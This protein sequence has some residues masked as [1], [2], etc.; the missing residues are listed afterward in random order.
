MTTI[1]SSV[2]P[3]PGSRP[4]T[5]AQTVAAVADTAR[6]EAAVATVVRLL[7][8][9]A[10]VD[11]SLPARH[12]RRAARLARLVRSEPAK[13][14]TF[15]LTDQVLRTGGA[16]RA[17][18][19]R[20]ARRFAAVVRASGT[21]G[22]GPVDRLLLGAGR[23]AARL[24]PG[25]VM[26]LVTRRL[27]TEATEV[28]LPAEDPAFA[29]HVA[30]RRA[31]GVRPNVNVIGEA[32]LS[33]VEAR[34]RLDEILAR[35]ARPDVDY[36]SVKISAI[37]PNVSALAFDA[38]VAAVSER[39][40]DLYRAAQRRQPAAFV[41]LDMEEYRD[42]A[43]TVAAFRTVLGEPEFA[44]LDAGIVLQ[45]YLPDSHGEAEQLAG[46]AAER[47]R[48]GGGRVKI[49]LVKG[50]NLAMERVDAEIHGWPLATYA[51]KAEVDASYKK[52]LDTLAD[53]RYDDAVT[54]GVASH[55]L[56]DVA[57]ALELRR[58][59]VAAGRPDRI[60]IEMLEGMAPA[61]AEAVRAVAGGLVAYTPIV[62]RTDFPAA[63]AYLVRRL[64]E[65]TSPENFL[66]HLFDI[67]PCNERFTREAERFAA[68]VHARAALPTA[69]H[70]SQ[71]R[72]LEAPLDDVRTPF[73]N[74][75]DTD[76]S[77]EANRRWLSAVRAAGSA[78][79][80]PMLG[81]VAEVDA[82]VAQATA[83][84]PAWA[85]RPVGERAALVNA[86]GDALAARRGELLQVMAVEA[87]KTVAEGDP[88]VS[89]AVDFARYYA[90]E[91]LRLDALAGTGGATAGPLGPVVVAPPWNF[92]VAIA[93]GGVLAALAAGNTVVLK[94]APQAVRCARL[95]A[96]CCWEAGVPRDVLQLV[97]VPDDDA[98]RRLISHPDVAAVV[99]TGAWDTAQLFLGWRPEL[100]LHAETSG[101][102][103]LVILASADLDLALRDLVRSAFGH[104]GQKCSAAS[105]AILEAPLYDDPAVLAR[106]RHAVTTLRTGPAT[107]LATD[108]GPLIGPPGDNLQRALTQLDPGERWLVEPRQIGPAQWTPGVRLGVRPG[109]WFHTT[110]CFGPVLGVLRAND[111]D[112]AL[113]LQNAVPFGLTAGL[114]TLDEAEIASWVERVEAGNL[115]INRGITGAIVRRQPFGGW[116]RSAVGPTAKAG[117]PNYVATLQRW[118][119]GGRP[120]AEVAAAFAAWMD[121][122]GRRAHDVSGLAAEGNEFRYRPVAGGVVVR[123]EA[124]ASERDVALARLAAEASGSPVRWSFAA[125][126]DEAGC[127]GA[128]EVTGADR[129]R[130][131]GGS[132]GPNGGMLLRRSAHRLG[133][134]VDDAAPVGEPA[135][136]LP[137]WLREQSVTRVRHRHG[138]LPGVAGR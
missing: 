104:A 4:G 40:A 32:I 47:H 85:S 130:L 127:A 67:A 13:E 68:A 94:P 15:A 110:E 70:R 114:H 117:G 90:R 129:L 93:A 136:E 54:I 22:F 128:L 2:Q 123:V 21:S 116:K 102:N 39:L 45:A 97:R 36:V 52:L 75:A 106:L 42:L 79:E 119:D 132:G 27:Q 95:V 96:V 131:L 57:W 72:R 71:D 10:A 26:P 41:N 65:N 89:E 81:G 69:P 66:T 88:E 46:W 124:G 111:L 103:A 1:P 35:L 92:P 60:E 5:L 64:D 113:A 11:R 135:V 77:L 86:V 83:A 53:P 100:R 99:L 37:S 134:A 121:A 9:A 63:I 28:I 48:V 49:R 31:G 24:L 18:D 108:V 137:R 118:N 138:R 87:G 61:H 76:F 122:Q 8:A 82:A 51:T 3:E 84:L 44:G 133:I 74:E 17:G 109:S 80:A 14:L 101:K 55:N 73:A 105:L 34:A 12:R 62:A 30:A 29:R 38:T 115:Y 33:E 56:F 43:L 20:A 23:H 25:L 120:L 91:A 112:E 107:D 7:D 59:L 126:E 98:G 16:G 6:V 50:A 58:E 19:A 78:A 125:D